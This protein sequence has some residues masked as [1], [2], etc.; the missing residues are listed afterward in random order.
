MKRVLMGIRQTASIMKWAFRIVWEIDKKTILIYLLVTLVGAIIPVLFLYLNKTI[1]DKVV[2]LSSGG[3]FFNEILVYI[4]IFVL[5]LFLKKIHEMLPS[6][7]FFTMQNKYAIGLQRKIIDTMQRVPLKYFNDSEFATRIDRMESNGNSVAQVIL[8]LFPLIGLTITIITLLITAVQTSVILFV[9]ALFLL[10][11]IIP[12]GIIQARK[13]HERWLDEGTSSKKSKYFSDLPMLH[14]NAKEFRLLRMDEF[15]RRHWFD[16]SEV[17]RTNRI[18]RTNEQQLSWQIFDWISKGFQLVILI[19]GVHLIQRGSLTIG[20]LTMFVGL[21][22]QLSGSSTAVGTNVM[23]MSAILQQLKYQR[24]FIDYK[25]NNDY[26]VGEI[27]ESK[28]ED[29][30]VP[31]FELNNVSF[32]YT[33]DQAVLKNIN[34]KIYEGESVALVG[35]NGAGKSTLTNLLLGFYAP[36]EGDI[37]YKG[38][39]YSE[40]EPADFVNDMGVS[41]QDFARFELRIRE[42]IA[43][44]DISKIDDDAALMNAAQKSGAL[45]II[46]RVRDGIDTWLGRWY[47]SSSSNLSGGEWQRLVVSRAHISNRNIMILD[48]PA[49]MLDPIA[50]LEQFNNLRDTANRRTS[51]LISHRI[52]FARMADKI[53]VM[54]EG[55]LM[56]FGT[57]DELMAKRG[58]YYE[59]FTTQASWYVKENKSG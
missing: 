14:P 38:K 8:T 28:T 2:V 22:Q 32:G 3:S 40:I 1:V 48:E 12:N 43:F 11:I 52:G 56:E 17:M 34:M 37:Y 9:I 20:G 27:E 59:M 6:V 47:K 42:N 25:Y 19:L 31:V 41:F 44:G 49:S 55:N 5:F 15:A 24:D 30:E 21:F 35:G 10:L 29:K 36:T 57:H 16:A 53:A 13:E 4:G 18:K 45:Q 7:L 58:L 26:P 50:E 33:P 39:H 46:K 51:I 23:S 54:N